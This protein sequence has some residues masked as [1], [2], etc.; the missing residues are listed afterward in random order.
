M[1]EELCEFYARQFGVKVCIIR[2]FNV[3]GPGQKE[4]FLIHQIITHAIKQDCI[5][6]LDLAPR[7]DYIYLDDLLEAIWQTVDQVQEYEVFNIGS[8]VSYSVKEVI[9]KVQ[10]IL[11][12]EKPVVC[13]NETRKNELNDVVADITH[14]REVLGWRPA[15]SLEQGLQEM[16]EKMTVLS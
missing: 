15:H 12:S 14:V 10:D 4:N 8:G 11:G 6:V 16:I 2:P 1:A 9:E 3:Y 7:R 5:Q 13:K